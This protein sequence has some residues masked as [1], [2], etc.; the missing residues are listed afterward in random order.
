[1]PDKFRKAFKKAWKE[2]TPKERRHISSKVKTIT[3]L[4]IAEIGTLGLLSV[5]PTKVFL[6]IGLALTAGAIAFFETSGSEEDARIA[7]K[8]TKKYRKHRGLPLRHDLERLKKKHKSKKILHEILG[9]K[10]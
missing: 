8:F 3:A 6:P 10:K 5:M 2:L 1:M 4:G 9:T 7:V